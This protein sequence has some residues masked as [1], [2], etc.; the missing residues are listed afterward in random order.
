MDFAGLAAEVNGS[1][2]ARPSE[3]VLADDD[4][5]AEAGE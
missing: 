5:D 2:P 1:A 4:D 3:D